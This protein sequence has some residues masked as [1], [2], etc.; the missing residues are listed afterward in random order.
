MDR[1]DIADTSKLV[2]EFVRCSLVWDGL[3]SYTQQDHILLGGNKSDKRSS[4]GDKII[5]RLLLIVI[6]VDLQ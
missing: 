4:W 1:K 3:S 2:K 6:V 5:E